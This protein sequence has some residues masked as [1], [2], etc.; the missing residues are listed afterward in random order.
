MSAAK[1]ADNVY[2][3]ILGMAEGLSIKQLPRKKGQIA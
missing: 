2:V 1:A 3:R